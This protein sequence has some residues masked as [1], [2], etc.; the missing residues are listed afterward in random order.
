MRACARRGDRFVVAWSLALVLLAGGTAGLGGCASSD[1]PRAG[2]DEGVNT[3]LSS[4][5]DEGEAEE[6]PRA[7][8]R[9]VGDGDPLDPDAPPDDDSLEALAARTAESLDRLFSEEQ[10]DGRSRERGAPPETG[11]E[12]AG[13]TGEGVPMDPPVPPEGA[14]A[15]ESEE[16]T[17]EEVD[18]ED[19]G[20]SAEAEA[21]ETVD[22]VIT[23][24]MRELVAALRQR[25]A[26]RRDPLPDYL[27]LAALEGAAPAI[28]DSPE[29]VGE[30]MGSLAGVLTPGEGAS[31]EALR[32]FVGGMTAGEAADGD[33]EAVADL[34]ESILEDLGSAQTLRIR[35]AELCTRVDGFGRFV[36][37]RRNTF[38][39]GRPHRMIVYVELDRFAHR[40]LSREERQGGSSRLARRDQW[41]VELSQEL[42]LYHARDPLLA[43][44]RPRERV[45]DTS[46]NRVRDFYVINEIELPS[47]LTV[48]SYQLKVV[49]RD[50]TSGAVAE[51]LIPID[52]VADPSLASQRD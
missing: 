9:P 29:P 7:R 19:E 38:L 26:D 45:V 2:E 17:P 41:A 23:R 44:R 22:E 28:L 3:G 39:A 10:E 52:I 14:E 32:R 49:M 6:R 31:L 47:T 40:E 13:L 33:P 46:R 1:G 4:L 36:P 35:R 21:G 43:W 48:G 42:N 8:R 16:E 51:A 37:F 15:D 18:P 24:S 5:L 12:P 25:A 30:S 34:M 20:A 50:E 27:A 11:G